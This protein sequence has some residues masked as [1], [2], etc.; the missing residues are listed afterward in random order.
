M[1]M[2]M[3]PSEEYYYAP[4]ERSN[5][6]YTMDR[7]TLYGPYASTFAHPSFAA[8]LAYQHYTLWTTKWNRVL[9]LERLRRHCARS[10]LSVGCQTPGML[11]PP[12]GE[13]GLTLADY[14]YMLRLT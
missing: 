4:D 6:Q 2:D 5:F 12:R 7:L 9:R 13:D 8:E 3:P 1:A 14:E 11:R 10:R